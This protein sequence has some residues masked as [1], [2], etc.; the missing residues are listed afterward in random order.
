M[1][2]T[3]SADVVSST[4]MSVEDTVRMKSY[5]ERFFSMMKTVCPEAW[6]RIVRGDAVECVIPCVNSALRIALLLK[7]YVKSFDA[8]TG[9]A[10]FKKYGIRISI[11]IGELRIADKENGIVDG[12]AIYL[13]G[14]GLDALNESTKGTLLFSCSQEQHKDINVIV[15]FLDAFMNKA[16]SRQCFIV[17]YKLLGGNEREIAAQTGIS[18]ATVNQHASAAGW[19]QIQNA[20]N[21]FEQLKFL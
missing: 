5:L 17:M 21:Y 6:G 19:Q 12:E 9:N 1:Y 20:V 11:G 2:A 16:T 18:Q 13:S 10:S 4:S 15:G 7:C 14:R 8:R 3:I